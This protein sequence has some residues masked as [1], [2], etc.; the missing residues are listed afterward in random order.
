MQL[1]SINITNDTTGVAPAALWIA[2]DAIGGGTGS[3]FDNNVVDAYQ[4]FAD[5]DGNPATTDDVPD[6]V[7]NSWGVN[8]GF[9]GYS[10]CDH[11]WDVAIIALEAAGCV[12]EFSSGNVRVV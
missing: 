6:I 10:D 4:W 8:G 11:R 9:S 5:P 3:V 2:D 1:D 12:V 7:N